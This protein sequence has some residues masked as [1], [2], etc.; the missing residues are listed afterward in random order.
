MRSAKLI[1]AAFTRMRTSPGPA[2]GSG[3]SRTSRTSGGP[4]LL[5]QIWRM[6]RSVPE[7]AHGGAGSG[8]P[9]RALTASE[10]RREEAIG[11]L[12]CAIEQAL[13]RSRPVEVVED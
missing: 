6:A 7:R 8:A 5:I 3:A 2:S 1:P 4:A 11:A 9:R 12:G 10:I 13:D